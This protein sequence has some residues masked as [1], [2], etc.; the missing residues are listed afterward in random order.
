MKK[1][2]LLI[3]WSGSKKEAKQTI[4]T[5]SEVLLEAF[6][7]KGISA[8]IYDPE[9]KKF[10]EVEGFLSIEG[11]IRSRVF[12]VRFLFGEV[13]L[14]S[15]TMEVE[16]EKGVSLFGVLDYQEERVGLTLEDVYEMLK[17]VSNLKISMP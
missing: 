12:L 1:P 10:Y 11:V 6:G 8:K 13:I 3:E 4:R 5:V 15:W 2:S 17:R 16:V 14:Q 9:A 7:Q